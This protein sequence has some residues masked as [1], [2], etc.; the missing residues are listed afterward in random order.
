M[1]TS[2]RV[3]RTVEILACPGIVTEV[4]AEAQKDADLRRLAVNIAGDI[5]T[6][7]MTIK[8]ANSPLFRGGRRR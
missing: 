5:G 4:M 3:F 2:K 1:T 8:L 7:A 6:S